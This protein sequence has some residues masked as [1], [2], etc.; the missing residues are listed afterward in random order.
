MKPRVNETRGLLLHQCIFND[1]F[2]H[3]LTQIPNGTGVLAFGHG[4]KDHI[5]HRS[6]WR[7]RRMLG[8]QPK[9]RL[10]ET[11]ALIQNLWRIRTYS[12]FLHRIH[13]ISA[14]LNLWL[15]THT[16]GKNLSSSVTRLLGNLGILHRNKGQNV[17]DA[18]NDGLGWERTRAVPHATRYKIFKARQ[19]AGSG[20]VSFKSNTLYV[21]E[22]QVKKKKK[23]FLKIRGKFWPT[24]KTLNEHWKRLLLL[25]NFFLKSHFVCLPI[26]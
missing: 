23:F 5:A 1:L 24:F 6:Q 22:G 25:I 17:N 21:T 26:I 12:G 20:T 14:V 16:S 8:F 3:D 19:K 4:Q 11:L 9:T 10:L 2:S 15:S 13:P 7:A 18:T